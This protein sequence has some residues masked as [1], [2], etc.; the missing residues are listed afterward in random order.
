M[1][2]FFW[3]Y[4]LVLQDRQTVEESVVSAWL[5]KH[6]T[7]LHMHAMFVT[8]A[9]YPSCPLCQMMSFNLGKRSLA[10]MHISFFQANKSL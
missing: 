6:D 1:V 2:C 10:L 5:L 9:V 4:S 3:L 8:K 7:C